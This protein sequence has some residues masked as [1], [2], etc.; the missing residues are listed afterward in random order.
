M[1]KKFILT[2][3]ALTF[4]GLI[5]CE[6]T[7][8]K[9]GG[10][11]DM[12]NEINSAANEGSDADAKTDTKTADTKAPEAAPATPENSEKDFDD[13]GADEEKTKQAAEPPAEAPPDTKPDA[14]TDD[15]ALNTP[16]P[17]EEKTQPQPPPPTSMGSA[18]D[19]SSNQITGINYISSANGGSIEIKVSGKAS[20]AV[21]P[22]PAAN[23]YVIEVA[24]TQIAKSLKRPFIMKDFEGPFGAVNAYQNPGATTA[25]IVVQ[26]KGAGEPIIT[27]EGN[28]I[29]VTPAAADSV[30]GQDKVAPKMADAEKAAAD[31]TEETK[32]EGSDGDSYNVKDAQ[33]NEQALGARTLDEFLTGN[34]RFF[35]R[36]I[37]IQTNDAEV[38]DVISFIAEESGINLV[39]GDDVDGK[40]SLKLR[41]VP[42]DQA[43][44]I[45]MRSRNLGYVRQG[46]VIR[47]TKLATLQAE[48]TA[49]K[50]IVDAQQ[51]LTPL[52]VK[53]LPVSYA[54]V[55]D[56]VTQIKPFLTPTRGQI[57]ADPRTTALII[58]DTAEKLLRI[59]KLVKEL[60]IPPA[61]VMIEGKIVEATEA[62]SRQIGINWRLSGS[63]VNVANSGGY[64]G[65]PITALPNLAIQPITSA[66]LPT[67]ALFGVNVGV[68]DVIGSLNATLGLAEAD[69]LLRVISS[70]RIVTMNKEKA[71]ITQTS[72]HIALT[73]N[74]DSFGN[75]TTSP[76]ASDLNL[77]LQVTPQI[78][79]EGSVVLEVD[80]TR[81]FAGAIVDPVS[82]AAPINTRQAQTKVLVPNGQTAV[83]GGIYES[84]ETE[85][86]NGVPWFKDLPGI[87]WLFKFKDDERNKD[88]LLLFL[89][90]RILNAKDQST[91]Q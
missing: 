35:G 3:F 53:V 57:V 22:N 86:D 84:Q 28:N 68:L 40:I 51:S 34:G 41:Q 54:N 4:I 13:F 71:V 2:I 90:P 56:L 7:P 45:V 18:S 88:E 77:K 91:T 16:P 72:Q 37:S 46:N 32:A 6:T 59:E 25:R 60:D 48:A 12:V 82:Q 23:Q 74:K 87:G 9:E 49:A 83:I 24:N 67:S 81:Q 69:S 43:L 44:V 52:K 5:G 36:P 15:T 10:D 79:A 80:L 19:G 14:K 8:T 70:P 65:T 30:T 85:T 39:M 66:N 29:L 33:K 17:V 63:P 20:Y 27:Q 1:A 62:F 47:I 42:W 78:T 89:T 61:Q 50:Q 58:T 21:R 75:V 55:T 26:M 73:S 11:D 64:G 31:A 38:R 76:K